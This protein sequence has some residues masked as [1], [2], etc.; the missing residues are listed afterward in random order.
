M[1][2]RNVMRKAAGLLIEMPPEPSESAPEEFAGKPEAGES[3][4]SREKPD[5]DKLLAEAGIKRTA[6]A[7]ST[8]AAAP[9]KTPQAKTVEQVVRDAPGPNLDEI[10][11][12]INAAPGSTLSESTPLTPDGTVNFVAIYRAAKLPDAPFSAEKMLEMLANLPPDVSLEIK[13]QM[14]KVTLGALG[15]S[16][17][18]TPENIVADASRKLAALTA[19]AENYG[20]QSTLAVERMEKEIGELQKQ[21]EAKKAA[22]ES[23]K[24]KNAQLT[25]SCEAESNRLDDVLEFFSL[26]VPPSKYAAPQKPTPQNQR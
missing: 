26:D 13:R 20:R 7:G 14:V 18:A 5:I 25:K 8:P 24:T 23:A 9:H 4:P 6:P 10:K 11:T 2:L 19:F 21:I 3:T 1:S 22:I 17:G 15:Q 16:V 12:Q